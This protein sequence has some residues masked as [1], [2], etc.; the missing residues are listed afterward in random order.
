MESDYHLGNLN[1]AVRF[2]L[3]ILDPFSLYILPLM[4]IKLLTEQCIEP[5]ARSFC[6]IWNNGVCRLHCC[7]SAT[8]GMSIIFLV[9][10]LTVSSS[11]LTLRFWE[12]DVATAKNAVWII[13]FH[14]M[15]WIKIKR[16]T[17]F[18]YVTNG[19]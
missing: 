15:W 17:A 11:A 13:V 16:S 18:S 2:F 7:E 1:Y 8:P 3:S 9:I 10:R 5:P 12:V 14:Y 6:R 19:C 4:L